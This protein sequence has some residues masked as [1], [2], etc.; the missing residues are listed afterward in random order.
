MFSSSVSCSIVCRFCTF[1]FMKGSLPLLSFLLMYCQIQLSR[2]LLAL[3]STFWIAHCRNSRSCFSATFWPMTV[4][5]SIQSR[6]ESTFAG[7]D[8]GEIEG[9]CKEMG[10]SCDE[11]D[12]TTFEK[13]M[14][15]DEDGK[16]EEEEADEVDDEDTLLFKGKAV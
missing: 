2:F 13:V 12:A 5:P 3:S 6:V 14:T 15:G 9:D 10:E 8:E 4:V 16:R 7:A 1:T 11:K